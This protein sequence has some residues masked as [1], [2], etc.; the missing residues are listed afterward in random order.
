VI[1]FNSHF[2]GDSGNSTLAVSSVLS[3]SSGE[4]DQVVL[5]FS[6]HVQSAFFCNQNASASFTNH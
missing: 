3:T 4:A 1:H 2:K 6:P 5:S